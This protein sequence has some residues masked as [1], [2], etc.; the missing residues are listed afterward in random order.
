[1]TTEIRFNLKAQIKGV[2]FDL[3]GTLVDTAP[4]LI[5][6]LNMSLAS[7]NHPLVSLEEMRHV[8][9]DGS[10]ALARA[11][12]PHGDA[13]LHHEV[14]QG[15]LQSYE[16]VNGSH[17]RLFDGMAALLDYLDHCGIPYGIVTNKA[18]KY[19]RPL[20]E[21]LSLTDRMKTVISG[22]S[23]L[24]SKPHTAPMLLAAQ[25]L[26]CQVQ[27]ILYL[28]DAERDLVAAADSAMLGG[29]ALWGYIN[30]PAHTQNWPGDFSFESPIA[31]K[32]LLID[33]ASA[34]T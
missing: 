3:D 8:A 26:D 18:A 21:A 4:D 17:C 15:L 11:A 12:L 33:V 9:S 34:K 27:E 13:S 7:L 6:A 14:Q 30:D 16:Q 31:I 19:T 29:V 24:F 20:I 32:Q 23:T 10:L 22:D 25:Q 1:M 2:L 5:A 28:G